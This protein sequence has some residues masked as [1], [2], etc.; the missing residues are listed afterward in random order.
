MTYVNTSPMQSFMS[1]MD[2][3]IIIVNITSESDVS[4]EF[5]G[6][7]Y[8]VKYERNWYIDEDQNTYTNGRCTREHNQKIYNKMK[9]FKIQ[10]IPHSTFLAFVSIYCISSICDILAFCS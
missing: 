3:Q 2:S 9:N 7:V 5:R 4:I 8:T 10:E 1:R 6:Q